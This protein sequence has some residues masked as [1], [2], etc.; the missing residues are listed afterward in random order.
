MTMT[1]KF[2]G[3]TTNGWIHDIRL[4]RNRRT[5]L[6]F[7]WYCPVLITKVLDREAGQRVLDGR[8]TPGTVHEAYGAGQPGRLSGQKIRL[9]G[10]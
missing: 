10:C 8:V 1:A 4:G 6:Q 7:P 9:R 2:R 5:K 3:E